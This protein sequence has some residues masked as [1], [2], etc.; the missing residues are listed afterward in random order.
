MTINLSDYSHFIVTGAL[1]GS[2]KRFRHV[3]SNGLYA[4]GINLWNGS[5]HGV[6]RDNGK[7]Q[8]LKRVVN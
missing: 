8:R 1:Y 3:Y 4:L 5:V 7:R 2:G 6:R